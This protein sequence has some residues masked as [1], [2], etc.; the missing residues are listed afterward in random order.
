M[1]F[2]ILEETNMTHTNL[3]NLLLSALFLALCMVLPYLTLQV[4]T[5]GSMLLPMHLPVLLCG[6]VCGPVFGLAVGGIAP[7]LRSV[8]LGAPPMMPTAVAMTFELAVYGLLA[9]LF[10]KLFPK[11]IGFVYVSL[12]LAMIGGRLAWG[13]ASYILYGFGETAFTFEIFLGGAVVNALPGIIL[14][15]VL[16]PLI[17]IALDRAKLLKRS[18]TASA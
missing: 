18:E 3:K 17:V 12:I 2:F 1:V 5:F 8:T 13:A 10:Y 4:P 9:G 7:L 14:Q 16:I 6:F 15:I 11:K